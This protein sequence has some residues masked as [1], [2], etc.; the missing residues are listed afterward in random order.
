MAR[1]KVWLVTLCWIG[2][3]AAGIYSDDGG[4]WFGIAL[5][6]VIGVGLSCIPDG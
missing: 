3:M 1:V 2:A 4:V 5:G 6:I